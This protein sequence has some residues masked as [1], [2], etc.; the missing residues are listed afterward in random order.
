MDQPAREIVHPF[1]P[2]G[3]RQLFQIGYIRRRAPRTLPG[4]AKRICF[5]VRE[6]TQRDEYAKETD[7]D[8]L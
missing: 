4:P 2:F 3:L 8:L 6:L 7:G 5:G 1:V